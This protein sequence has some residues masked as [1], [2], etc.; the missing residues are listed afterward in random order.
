MLS[1]HHTDEIEKSEESR[2]LIPIPSLQL[3]KIREDR[4]TATIVKLRMNALAS[5]LYMKGKALLF[6]S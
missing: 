3:R 1:S 6:I 4:A 2:S 5:A